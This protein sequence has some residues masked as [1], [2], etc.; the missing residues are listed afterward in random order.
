MTDDDTVPVCSVCVANY[1]G[2]EVIADC[3]D[4]IL[5]Q[6]C[7]FSFEIIVHDDVSSDGS[8]DYVRCHYPGVRVIS[9]EKNV[10]FCVSN[11]RM[12]S[13][14]RGQYI[15]LL[16]NDASLFPDA[17]RSLLEHAQGLAKPAIL[18]LPQYDA[19]SGE[20]V[21]RG[22]L[23][24]PFLNP[25]PNLDVERRDVAMVSGACLWISRDMW[26]ELGGFPDWF[27]SLAED[28]YLA[29]LARLR[30][31]GV[32]VLAQSGFRHH[33]GKSLGGGGVR[34]NRLSTS[35]R[36][37]TLSERN[38]SFVMVLCFP[39]PL[40]QAL[41]LLHLLLLLLEGSMLAL[42]K[43]EP[44]LLRNIYLACLG[45]LWRKRR[46]LLALRRHVQQTRKIGCRKFVTPFVWVPHKVTLLL[47]Y[48]VPMIG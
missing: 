2:A 33:F 10:G 11:N 4:S 20:L 1:N 43:W 48:G 35:L 38:K 44:R 7:D 16:N 42:L 26:Q 19:N 40:F 24:D 47:R 45:S 23:S 32:Q 41:F 14:A 21:D 9:S 6:N 31:Y 12:V 46:H 5:A 15:L 29:C 30:G 17:L 34:N 8:A 13:Q 22:S 28:M 3:L 25:V 18:G 39:A 27:D 37:R 36:R